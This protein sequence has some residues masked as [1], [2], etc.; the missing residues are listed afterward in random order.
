MIH[1]G[2]SQRH[3][4]TACLAGLALAVLSLLLPARTALAREFADEDCM[5]CHEEAL[6]KKLPDGSLR[7]LRVDLEVLG[8]SAHDGLS[9]SSCHPDVESLPHAKSLKPVDCTRCHRAIEDVYR[10]SI[11]AQAN[12]ETGTGEAASC[13]SCHGGHGIRSASDPLSTVHH[14]NLA[15]T[16]I[17][18]HEDQALIERHERMPG[19]DE[20]QSYVLSVHGQSNVEAADSKAATCNNCHGWHDT[21][22]VDS[23]ESSVSRQNVAQT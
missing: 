10:A 17:V 19:A 16:C 15:S 13:V 18:C 20:V 12:L 7:D 9:C 3:H 5:I 21:K 14:H 8:G 22:A 2:E 23:P 1:L 6:K 4:A 11:H